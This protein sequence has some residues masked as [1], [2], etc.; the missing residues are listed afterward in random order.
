[1]RNLVESSRRAIWPV[2]AKLSK[3]AKATRP[4]RKPLQMNEPPWPWPGTFHGLRGI[5][6]NELEG[7]V[8]RRFVDSHYNAYKRT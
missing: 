7:I 4:I 5:A 1:M 2:V 3:E 8:N 6:T